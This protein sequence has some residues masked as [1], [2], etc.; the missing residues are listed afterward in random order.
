MKKILALLLLLSISKQHTAQDTAK[1]WVVAFPITGYIVALNDSTQVVQLQVPGGAIIINEKQA[2]LLKAI[3]RDGAPDTAT[4]GFGKCQL[5]KGDYY[6]FAIHCYNKSRLPKKGDL[7]YTIINKADIFYGRIPKLAGHAITLQKVDETDFYDR[8]NVINSWTKQSDAA[9]TA[10]LTAD[11]N[12]TASEM[13]KQS[14][15]MDRKIN[16]GI[17]KDKMIFNVMEKATA[18]EVEDFLDYMIARPA[19]Y[20]GNS[21][22]VSE[23]FATWL[24]AGAPT[25]IHK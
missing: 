20:A 22:K 8:M 11:I 19:N 1:N 18:K 12:Y 15:G 10:A 16:S 6:Y 23:I 7:I 5:I 3:Y 2:G 17:Y 13:R 24:D 14:P 9:L 21:W 25:V 4:V